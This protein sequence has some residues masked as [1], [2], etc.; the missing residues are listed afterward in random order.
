[1]H[2]TVLSQRSASNRCIKAGVTAYQSVLVLNINTYIISHISP[3]DMRCLVAAGSVYHVQ[4]MINDIENDI[5]DMVVAGV[6]LN[7]IEMLIRSRQ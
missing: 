5:Y 3:N 6:Q 2:R 7:M 1:M 4:F